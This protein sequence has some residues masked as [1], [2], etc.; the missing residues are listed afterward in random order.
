M[1]SLLNTRRTVVAEVPI[2]KNLLIR[3][4]IRRLP[5]VGCARW[6]ERIACA[7]ASTG[8]FRF[9]FSCGFFGSSA[10]APPSRY[11]FTHW[12]AVVYGT[13]S[14]RAT[15]CVFNFRSTTARTTLMRNSRGQAC[16]SWCPR[17]ADRPILSV[18]L[19]LFTCLLLRCPLNSKKTRQVLGDYDIIKSRRVWFAA[20]LRVQQS[21]EL[22]GSERVQIG[23]LAVHSAE[24][25]ATSSLAP[26]LHRHWAAV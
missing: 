9:G 20:Q 22:H 4:R 12:I 21:A 18:P 1:P 6:V 3:S 17:D 26:L 24:I 23:H 15:S 5:A 13:F 16:R 25:R 7:R 10:S 2:P 8:F 11:A 19:S 14:C